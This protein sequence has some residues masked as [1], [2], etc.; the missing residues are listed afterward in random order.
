MSHNLALIIAL[1]APVVV[2]TVLR[3]NAALV[4]LSLCLGAILV[5]YVAGEANSLITLFS[6]QAGTM[7]AS[8]IQLALLFTPALITCILTVFSIHGRLKILLNVLPA[9]AASTLAVLLAVPLLPYG[10][11]FALQEQAVWERLTQ[12]QALIVS[13]GASVS[14]IFLWTQRRNFKHHDKRRKR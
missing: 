10:L 11:Q 1:A 6:D 7:S 2:F 9:L 14:L 8:S 12:A 5:Q 3:I 13:L 4:F